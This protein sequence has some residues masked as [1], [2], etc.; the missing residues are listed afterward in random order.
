MHTTYTLEETNP[1]SSTT[2]KNIETSK[3]P[4]VVGLINRVE[5]PEC[6]HC[7]RTCDT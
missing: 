2:T 4:P 6:Y 3:L 7:K 5:C 1:V